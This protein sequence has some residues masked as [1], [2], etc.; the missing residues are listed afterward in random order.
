MAEKTTG[1]TTT[2]PWWRAGW[3][4]PVVL[5]VLAV[6]FVLENRDLVSIRLLIPLVVMPQWAALTI[7]LVIGVIVGLLLRR[8]RR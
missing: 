4:L 6:I 1:R 3:V 5:L 8:R 2:T 7:T